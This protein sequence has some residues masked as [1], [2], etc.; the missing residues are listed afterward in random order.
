VLYDLRNNDWRDYL[1]DSARYAKSRMINGAH[2]I[3]L[4]D[5]LAFQRFLE[6]SS[7]HLLPTIYGTISKGQITTPC[8]EVPHCR[9]ARWLGAQVREHG[10][11]VIKPS[12]GGGGRDV[13]T[14][15][16][17]GEA[18][19]LNGRPVG[20]ADLLCLV[21]GSDGHMICEHVSQHPDMARLYPHATNTVRV[22]LMQDDYCHP[23]IAAAVLRVGTS[24]SAPTDNWRR[25]GLSA[26]VGETDGIVKKAAP[27][28][29]HRESVV[30]YSHHPETG[31]PIDGLR[32]PNW[33]EI[34]RGL[35]D[36]MRSLPMFRYVGWDVVVTPQGF[37]ILEGNN[38]SNVNL[39]QIHRPLLRDERVAAFY[40]R[41]GVLRRGRP[42][43][44]AAGQRRRG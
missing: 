41:H 24:R 42:Q 10:R 3:L 12:G 8:E 22:L 33:G 29:A 40:R 11:L 4:D 34:K 32:I 1:S 27:F 17:D 37:R 25:G 21:A 44:V 13:L 14:L 43:R 5:K 31:A 2:G 7:G 28:P 36:L 26:E 9:S 15:Q 16:I 6:K 38:F 35:A 18:M 23:F 30:W 20:E 19:R 39:I